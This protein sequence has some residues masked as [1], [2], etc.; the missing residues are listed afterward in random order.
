LYSAIKS[1]DTEAQNYLLSTIYNTN[2]KSNELSN[3]PDVIIVRCPWGSKTQN[4]RFLCR[5][6]L[7]L[8]KVCYKVSLCENCQRHSCMAFI[9]VSVH[10]EMIGGG[11]PI[12]C[13][14]L[15]NTYLPPCTTLIF[16][17]FSLVVPQP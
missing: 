10:T 9:C 8:K 13:E 15:A 3:Y 5:I 2:R 12:L 17:I 4:G 16:N 7:C 1:K 6:A 14:N 11:R